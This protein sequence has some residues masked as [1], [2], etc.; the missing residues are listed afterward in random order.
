[1]EQ[2]TTSVW[3][4]ATRYGIYFG[5]ISI[6]LSVLIWATS[7]MENL[8]IWGS[9]IIGLL[10][11]VISFVLILLFSF[12]YRNKEMGGFISFKDAFV[13]ALIM[14]IVSTIIS[15]LYTYIFNT[16]IDPGY[17]ERLMAVMQQKTIS[18]MEQ[19]GASETQI[20]NTMEK[21]KVPTVWK[22]VRQGLTS[23]IIVGSIVSLICAAIVKK[24]ENIESADII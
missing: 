10:S 23:G 22:T 20:S 12:S 7:I 18:Y 15:T 9:V 6:L 16:L 5:I 4:S 19:V 13:F 11:I 3:K 2:Q 24:K 17:M 21:F 1:M 8:G 14:V